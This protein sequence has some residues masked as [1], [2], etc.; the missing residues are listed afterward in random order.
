MSKTFDLDKGKQMKKLIMISS[1]TLTL[2]T[3]VAGAKTP[4]CLE[5]VRAISENRSENVE[6]AVQVSFWGSVFV[7]IPFAVAAGPFA[8]IVIIGGG[9]AGAVAISKAETRARN[10]V[11]LFEEAA[12]GT[13]GR[14]T[15]KLWQKANR[16][17][18][19]KFK[20]M[21]YADFLEGI[22]NANL[23]GEACRKRAVP[24]KKAILLTI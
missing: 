6:G 7:S 4:S 14:Q 10:L 5:Q 16:R 24:N 1:L 20:G 9:T 17:Y 18:P 8:P 13:G 21:S 2:L 23:S 19:D 3:T 22:N 15:G 11:D 12:S